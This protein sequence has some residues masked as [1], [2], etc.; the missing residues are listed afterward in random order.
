MGFRDSDRSVIRVIEM[1]NERRARRGMGEARESE[2]ERTRATGW[3]AAGRER[4]KEAGLTGHGLTGLPTNI[5][6]YII[7]IISLS[8]SC[9]RVSLFPRQDLEIVWGYKISGYWVF[10]WSLEAEK[11]DTLDRY[12]GAFTVEEDMDVMWQEEVSRD[13]VHF[14]FKKAREAMNFFAQ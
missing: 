7:Y 9:I 14:S 8:L 3:T 5:Y 1:V 4:G 12:L 10:D 11:R 2:K 13:G 6:L